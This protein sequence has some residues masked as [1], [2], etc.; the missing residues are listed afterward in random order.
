QIY[1]S[2][3]GVGGPRYGRPV[4]KIRRLE[5]RGARAVEHEMRV[6]RRGAVRDHGDRTVRGMGRIS[7]DL[8]IQD[9]GQA[10][11]ALS[12][13]A[14]RVH[15]VVELDAQ[16]L[17]LVARPARMVGTVFSTQSAIESEGLSIANFDFASEPPPLAATSHS[18][19]L[20]GTSCTLITAGVLSLVFLRPK[21][22]S[23][24]TEARSLLSGSRYAW[25]TPS[26]TTSSSDS[27]KSKRTPMPI[28][29]NTLTMPVSW[30]IGRCP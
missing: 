29:R 7:S 30:Q 26:L 27:E 3:L 25:R 24:S 16:L 22:D 17:H 15:L 10:A 20:P 13:D 19:L 11:Q 2:R 8:D 9:G 18:S 4:R 5:L 14:E 21:S 6:P 12:A 23:S 1:S 28:L